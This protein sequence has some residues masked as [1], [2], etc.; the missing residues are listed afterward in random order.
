MPDV[1]LFGQ[2]TDWMYNQQ[3]KHEL[4]ESHVEDLINTM[5][6]FELLQVISAAL[7]AMEAKK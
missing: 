5:T 7:H 6:N 3:R 2:V 1:T 4:D